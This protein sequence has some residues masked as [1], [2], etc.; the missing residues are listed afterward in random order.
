MYQSKIQIFSE[1][2]CLLDY[3]PEE[4]IY[5]IPKQLLDT[6]KQNSDAKYFI[7]IDTKKSLVNQEILKETKD[8]LMVLKY[9][10]WSNEEEQK[11]IR[12]KLL[13]NEEKYQKKLK[14]KYNPDNIFKKI[15]NNKIEEVENTALVE[16]KEGNFLKRIL[17]K[18]MNFSKRKNF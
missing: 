3:F 7:K 9:N 6:I 12:E 1:L 17:R 13:Q 16:Y 11:S 8:M 14:E 15:E 18:V 5:K 10:Y 2:S 4:Y